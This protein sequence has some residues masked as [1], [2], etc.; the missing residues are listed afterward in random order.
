MANLIDSIFI[1]VSSGMRKL[2]GGN[3]ICVTE[4]YLVNEIDLTI[5]TQG[6]FSGLKITQLMIPSNPIMLC[7]GMATCWS[8]DDSTLFMLER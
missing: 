6:V 3:I 1:V 5:N 8:G 7:R 4:D 2:A